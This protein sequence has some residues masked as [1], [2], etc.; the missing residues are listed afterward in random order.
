MWCER[1]VEYVSRIV[2]DQVID[3]YRNSVHVTVAMGL[4]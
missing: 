1:G 3:Y 4:R 2:E